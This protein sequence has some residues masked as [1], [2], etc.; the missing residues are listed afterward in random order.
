VRKAKAARKK[1]ARVV[2]RGYATV[3]RLRR[4]LARLPDDAPVAIVYARAEGRR[5]WAEEDRVGGLVLESPGHVSLYA[6]RA[7]A[8]VALYGPRD[9]DAR[10]RRRAS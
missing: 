10:R 1:T 6:E 4:A 9:W 2:R 7:R 5:E 3:G 8:C